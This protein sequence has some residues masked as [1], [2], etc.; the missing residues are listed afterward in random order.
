MTTIKLGPVSD[1][2][3]LT[4]R[5]LLASCLSGIRGGD[6]NLTLS[7]L[8]TEPFWN[9]VAVA[10]WSSFYTSIQLGFCYIVDRQNV[11]L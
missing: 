9:E 1:S 10:Y 3:W 5:I 11:I 4:V 6:R 7:L 8:N 2:S